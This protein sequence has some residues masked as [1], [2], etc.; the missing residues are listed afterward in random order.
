MLLAGAVGLIVCLLGVAW[1]DW[2]RGGFRRTRGLA[3]VLVVLV[4][5]GVI[6]LQ[7]ALGFSPSHAMKA[8]YLASLSPLVGLC[9]ALVFRLIGG[10]QR[11]AIAAA[12]CVLLGT[13]TFARI[14]KNW[15]RL[16]ANARIMKESRLIID[17]VTRARL[18]MTLARIKPDTQVFVATQDHILGSEAWRTADDFTFVTCLRDWSAR[19]RSKQL[20]VL[21]S[22][23]HDKGKSRV[24]GTCWY[25]Q[26]FKAR[27]R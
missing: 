22:Q 12:C 27:G 16:F 5:P 14:D 11:F 18:P 26:P 13:V 21:F 20:A 3:I 6:V 2:P 1:N 23:T 4:V 8:K 10:R 25:A 9:A 24:W 15:E 7:Y 17:D 19:K